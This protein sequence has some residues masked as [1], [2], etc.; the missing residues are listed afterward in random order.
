[1]NLAEI[2]FPR[3]L[4]AENTAEAIRQAL[5]ART[6]KFRPQSDFVVPRIEVATPLKNALKKVRLRGQI[7]CGFEDIASKLES[8]RIGIAGVRERTDAPYG[9]RISRLLLFSNDGAERL[10]RHIEHILKVHS[11]R[12]LGCLLN[13]DSEAFGHLITNKDSKIKIVMVEHKDAVCE[14]LR[15][16]IVTSQK[17]AE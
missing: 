15:A 16:M 9:K 13:I 3:E 17:P 2:R 11:P 1:M 4:E 14:I 5:L 7:R 6:V 12:L 10:Y 8:E